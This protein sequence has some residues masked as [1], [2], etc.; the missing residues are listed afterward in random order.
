[1]PGTVVSINVSQ[2][3]VPKRPVPEARVGMTGLVGDA[4]RWEHHGGPL[5]A[6]CLWAQERIEALRAEGHAL[7]PGA[8]GENL[9]LAGLDWDRLGPGA[10][11]RV[12]E[13]RLRVTDY[14]KPC[15][16]IAACFAGGDFDRIAQSRHPG[17]SRLYAS[18]LEGGTIRV[19]DAVELVGGPSA[20][21][22]TP[23]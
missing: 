3:G 7:E 22:R 6:V 4:Q 23:S 16:K 5:R 20:L 8:A 15:R 18:V 10:E 1:V 2:G 11:L 9:T 19:G 12:G 21:T 13:V 17:W 14:T